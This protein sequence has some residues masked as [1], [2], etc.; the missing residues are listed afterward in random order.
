LRRIFKNA[1]LYTGSTVLDGYTLVIQ[2]GLISSISGSSEELLVY[3]HG[4]ESGVDIQEYDLTGKSIAPAFIDLQIYGARGRLLNNERTPEL[5]TETHRHNLE[6]GTTRYQITLSTHLDTVIDEAIAL[7][8][9]ALKAGDPG[10]LGLHLEGP[11]INPVKRGAHLVEYIQKPT[12]NLLKRLE[13]RA[14]LA[15]TML[16]VAPEYLDNEMVAFLSHTGWA[17]SAGHSDATYDEAV[18]GFENGITACTHLYN[19]MSPLTSR[20]PGLTGAAFNHKTVMAS[21]IADGVHCDFASLAIAKRIMED[22][23]FLIT[24][25]VTA[26]PTGPYAFFQGENCFVNAQGTLSGS[27]LSMIQAVRN[28]VRYGGIP[29]DEA[30]RMASTYPAKLIGRE[31]LGLLKAG[32]R[33]DLLV[34]DD[35][36]NIEEVFY[37]GEAVLGKA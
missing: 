27:A 5:L 8:A 15:V 4:I 33:A 23:L 19:A 14:M 3:R 34:L 13:Q 28:C 20:A 16:T 17:I 12:L 18:K 30:L 24:D 21:I 25:A 10:L 29:L 11:F 35:R 26:C 1:R 2:D 37:E 9:T 36:L 6:G 32:A 22:R 31:D 7:V